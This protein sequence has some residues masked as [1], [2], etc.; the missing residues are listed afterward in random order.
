MTTDSKIRA[1]YLK[2]FGAG[3]SIF[4]LDVL[5][6]VTLKLARPSVPYGLMFRSTP[7]SR[8]NKVQSPRK[9]K[10]R[11]GSKRGRSWRAR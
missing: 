9:V 2:L 4:V 3:F 10:K 5:C 7:A 1:Q 8:T 6:H 11:G